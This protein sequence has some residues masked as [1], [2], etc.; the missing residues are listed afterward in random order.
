[1]EVPCFTQEMG[2]LRS[3]I[4]SPLTSTLNDLVY[5]FHS[6]NVIPDSK[7][8]S[9][10]YAKKRAKSPVRR[11]SARKTRRLSHHNNLARTAVGLRELAKKIG[12]T[13]LIWECPP[14]NVMIV[15]KL[16]DSSLIMPTMDLATWLLKIG[17]C[18]YIQNEISQL[19]ATIPSVSTDMSQYNRIEI[20]EESSFSKLSENID[21][22]I[23]LG[24]DG[25]VLYTAWLFQQKVPPIIPFNLGSLGFLTV[26]DAI[27][28]ESTIDTVLKS[29][30]VTF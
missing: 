8:S 22:V 29:E 2:T 30:E 24:G 27:S 23:T 4:I 7:D 18:P 12:E 10:D 20:W 19:F 5:E 11:M 17:L 21:F 14:R 1:V 25:T 3:N 6:G 26:F 15:T 13:S 9:Q 16:C 28:M